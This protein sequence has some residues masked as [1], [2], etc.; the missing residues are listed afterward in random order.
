MSLFE[1]YRMGLPLF[2]P[3]P[4][5]LTKWHM[6]Y[7]VLN[8]RTWSTVFGRSPR[9]SLSVIKRHG[10]S[11]STLRSDPNDEMNENSVLEWISL[12]DF[13]QWPHITLFKSWEDLFVLLITTDLSK[14]SLQMHKYNLQEGRRIKVTWS[15]ILSK[16]K[17]G[18]DIRE[19]EKNRDFRDP[20]SPD[21]SSDRRIRDPGYLD[22]RAPIEVDMNSALERSYGV[23]VNDNCVGIKDSIDHKDV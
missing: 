4:I 3:S 5:L 20:H 6:K 9:D 2:V 10:N 15:E 23:T 22:I 7:G 13:Y 8:E 21:R 14:I 11:N 18:K 17:V 12:A 16:I 1:F 19:K